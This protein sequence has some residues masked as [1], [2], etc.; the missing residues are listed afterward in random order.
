MWPRFL[1]SCCLTGP[2]KIMSRDLLVQIQARIQAA[3]E[4]EAWSE[5]LAQAGEAIIAAPELQFPFVQVARICYLLGDSTM[6]S[7][8][9]E[10]AKN[11]Q[12][13]ADFEVGGLIAQEELDELAERWAEQSRSKRSSLSVNRE[14]LT[15]KSLHLVAGGD[16]MLGRQMPGW[17]GLR[18]AKSA[19][20]KIAPI[21]QSADLAMV[22]LEVCV[23]TEGDFID[24][25]GRQPYYYHCLPEMLDVLTVAGI[26]CVATGNNHAMDFGPDA[27]AQQT[28]ILEAAGFLHF[29]AGPNAAEASRPKYAKVNGVTVAFIGVETETP[30]MAATDSTAG[31]HYASLSDMVRK[32]SG[33][34]ALARAHADFVVVSPHWGINWETAPTET[35]RQCARQLIDLGA[36]AVFGH[37]AHILQ[38]IEFHAGRPIVYDMGTLLFDRVAQNTMKDSAL[39][40]LV[41]NSLGTCELTVRP[42]RLRTARAEPAEGDDFERIRSLVKRLS[43]ELNSSVVL[44]SSEDGLKFCSQSLPS[45][46]RVLGILPLVKVY[47]P[48]RPPSVTVELRA[49][50]SNLAFDRVPEVEG[51]WTKPLQ[52][53]PSLFILGARHASTVRPGRGSICEVYF[54]ASAPTA[55]TRVEARIVGLDPQGKEA[56]C[57]IHPV[58]EGIH[59]PARWSMNEVICD[60]VCV[61]PVEV[62]PDGVYT[63]CWSLVD[64]ESGSE[65]PVATEDERVLKGQIVIG[66]LIVSSV[67]PNGVAGLSTPLQLPRFET[68]KSYGFGGWQGRIDE[69]WA[70]E[71]GP[72]VKQA[73]IEIDLSPLSP[74]PIVVRDF[75]MA[76]VVRIET[77]KG[78]YFFK[79]L[80]ESNHF[81]PGLLALLSQSWADRIARPVQIC[82]T[83]AWMLTPD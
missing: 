78:A 28:Q 66:H 55:G 80:E 18:G 65:M 14:V 69:F 23:S 9:L 20:A 43:Q 71:A 37:S 19:F 27:L 64:L 48:T 42:V 8:Y 16:V 44:E 33:S 68:A 6:G 45:A 22:N 72:W 13:L 32:L 3:L 75:P 31:I 56:F 26:A 1:P 40:D 76:L 21:L 36:D 41:W 25:G 46:V 52:V 7:G 24:K 50:R 51:L 60:R 53:N 4:K 59:P 54:R 79:A 74:E 29:G 58:A 63:L 77:Q 17:V 12:L 11:T 47:E 2:T 38:G 49:L 83:R 30:K 15:V 61:R 34:I 67:A 70:T 73:L 82:A 10:F 35:V 62:V 81:E 5:A 39:F 57:Y